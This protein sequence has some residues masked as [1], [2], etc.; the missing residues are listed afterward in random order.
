MVDSNCP[1]GYSSYYGG[2]SSTWEVWAR[3]VVLGLIILG[4]IL[5]F[6]LFSCISSRRRRRMGYQPYRGTGWAMG[7]T[8]LGHAPATYNQQPYHAGQPQQENNYY[9]SSSNPPPAYGASQGY[10][11][12][13]NDVELQSP[14][15]AYGGY[16]RGDN[17]YAAPP[18]PPPAK[19]DGI[20][21]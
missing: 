13:R 6:F 3:W 1:N 9:Q 2:C 8:P 20:I 10:Y 5:I 16:N 14:P 19:N 18:G 4:A 21:R 15:A 12:G 7:R 11:G 17:A